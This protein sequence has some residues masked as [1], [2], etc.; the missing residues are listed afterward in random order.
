[1]YFRL[2]GTTQIDIESR[3]TNLLIL[4]LLLHFLSPFYSVEIKSNE[5][6]IV[7]QFLTSHLWRQFTGSPPPVRARR[8]YLSDGRK[9]GLQFSSP[10]GRRVIRCFRGLRFIVQ[11]LTQN[12][13]SAAYL[14]KHPYKGKKTTKPNRFLMKEKIINCSYLIRFFSTYF[15]K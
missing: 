2:V 13:W 10:I 14:R 7:S 4:H 6:I 1:M 11:P 5:P 3:I 15:N 8:F 9:C 12:Y